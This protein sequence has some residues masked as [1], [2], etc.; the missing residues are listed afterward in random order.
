[1]FSPKSNNSSEEQFINDTGSS[2]KKLLFWKCNVRGLF[3]EQILAKD[4]GIF[5]ERLLFAKLRTQCHHICPTL[6]ELSR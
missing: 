1:V 2:P 4:S 3:S 5:P 6:G